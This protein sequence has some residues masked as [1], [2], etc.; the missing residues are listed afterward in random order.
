M[1]SVV[2]LVQSG[3]LPTLNKDAVNVKVLMGKDKVSYDNAYK[4]VTNGIKSVLEHIGTP[5]GGRGRAIVDDLATAMVNTLTIDINDILPMHLFNQGALINAID[6]VAMMINYLARMITGIG[7]RDGNTLPAN[8]YSGT[9]LDRVINSFVDLPRLGTGEPDLSYL[10]RF[11][12]LM[13]YLFDDTVVHV[14]AL[15]SIKRIIDTLLFEKN[16]NEAVTVSY[17]I[18]ED[19]TQLIEFNVD[20]DTLLEQAISNLVNVLFVGTESVD[21]DSKPDIIGNVGTEAERLNSEI[22]VIQSYIVGFITGG[23]QTWVLSIINKIIPVGT[24]VILRTLEPA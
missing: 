7:G 13:T 5:R 1:N 14:S 2:D 6:Y 24:K 3:I 17:S 9:D 20:I 4:G 11:R 8:S 10:C 16:D 22:E 23:F 21:D 18:N 15:N 19:Y 12:T